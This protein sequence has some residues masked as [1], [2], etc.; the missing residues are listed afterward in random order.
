MECGAIAPDWRACIVFVETCLQVRPMILGAVRTTFG[1]LAAQGTFLSR[2]LVLLSGGCWA[3][4]RARRGSNMLM[5][6]VMGLLSEINFL[7]CFS[8]GTGPTTTDGHSAFRRTG[9]IGLG[10]GRICGIRGRGRGPLERQASQGD[11]CFCLDRFS[12]IRDETFI[13]S[14]WQI[15]GCFV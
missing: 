2:R 11:D 3:T 1:D 9:G 13:F 8:V 10:G 12:I 4:I 6:G 7:F 14:R 5:C 15:L